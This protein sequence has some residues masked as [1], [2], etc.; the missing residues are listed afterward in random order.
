MS[1]AF[2]TMPSLG[3]SLRFESLLFDSLSFW[4]DCGLSYFNWLLYFPVSLVII[5]LGAMNGLLFSDAI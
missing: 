3:R 5:V 1:S 4:F 2:D